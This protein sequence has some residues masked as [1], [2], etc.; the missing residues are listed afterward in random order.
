MGPSGGHVSTKVEDVDAPDGE[1]VICGNGGTDDGLRFER[2]IP[3]TRGE[4]DKM[5]ERGTEDGCAGNHG[6]LQEGFD[7]GGGSGSWHS[8]HR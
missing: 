2:V 1:T 7:G 4:G 5:A 8:T 6:S 3:S